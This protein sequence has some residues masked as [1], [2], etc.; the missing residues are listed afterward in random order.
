MSQKQQGR[1]STE[2]LNGSTTRFPSSQLIRTGF[3]PQPHDSKH[4]RRNAGAGSES[5]ADTWFSVFMSS[6]RKVL[7]ISQC[8]AS[9]LPDF[10]RHIILFCGDRFHPLHRKL[11]AGG[12]NVEDL[13]RLTPHRQNL[14]CRFISGSG[15]GGSCDER[16]LDIA[17]ENLTRSFRVVGLCERFRESLLLMMGS[18]GWEV[19]FY[20]NH[21]VA[22]IRPSAEPR[23]IDAI[24]EHN[25]LDVELYDFAEKLFEE[26][27]RKNAHVIRDGLAALQ[28]TPKP[29]PFGKFC[30]S[31]ESA[32]RFLLSKIASAL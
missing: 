15:V 32:S 14:Q 10:Y 16:V 31:T 22:K 6:C 28:G 30:R 13:I 29:G 1:R 12:L 11:R 3:A 19:P 7:S 4:F 27:L 26:N 9:R 21:K 20:E 25:R 24:R 23:V 5:C 8:Y 2:S 17:K 18:F